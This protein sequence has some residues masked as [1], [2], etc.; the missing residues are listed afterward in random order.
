MRPTDTIEN[1]TNNRAKSVNKHTPFYYFKMKASN[2]SEYKKFPGLWEDSTKIESGQFNKSCLLCES[3]TITVS[4]YE[5]GEKNV[6]KLIKLY[7][8]LNAYFFHLNC[9][10]CLKNVP[11]NSQMPRDLVQI[12]L[13]LGIMSVTSLNIET[14]NWNFDS[15]EPIAAIKRLSD[16]TTQLRS[17][18]IPKKTLLWKIYKRGNDNNDRMEA[19]T[20]TKTVCKNVWALRYHTKFPDDL[21]SIREI[22][23]N[24]L[25]TLE[26]EKYSTVNDNLIKFER[27]DDGECV[28]HHCKGPKSAIA[29]LLKF[30]PKNGCHLDEFCIHLNCMRE[31]LELLPIKYKKNIPICREIYWLVSVY[32]PYINVWDDGKF[33]K[34][35]LK[36]KH[37]YKIIDKYKKKAINTTITDKSDTYGIKK[38]PKGLYLQDLG[39]FTSWFRFQYDLKATSEMFTIEELY[40]IPLYKEIKNQ[41]KLVR[42]TIWDQWGVYDGRPIKEY[43]TSNNENDWIIK[44]DEIQYLSNDD[45]DDDEDDD[46]ED[47]DD[48]IIKTNE[49]QHLSDDDE[50]EG[51]SIHNIPYLR[52]TNNKN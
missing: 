15:T 5:D 29:G 32:S 41:I 46:G 42:A 38:Q 26:G 28:Y 44:I 50:D 49:I 17:D 11:I 1:Y 33:E 9:L 19:I 34:I 6:T 48:S 40:N 36:L 47:E 16:D 18:Y 12:L 25:K 14:K 37:W 2:K 23:M 3:K 31:L 21:V 7:Y 45:D 22:S 4:H 27:V 20:C 8:R 52:N 10:L 39:I 35:D 24:T 51:G 43:K 13:G 30:S